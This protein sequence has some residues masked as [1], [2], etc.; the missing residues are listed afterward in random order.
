M[1]K[2]YSFGSNIQEVSN[3]KSFKFD[4]EETN[5]SSALSYFPFLNNVLVSKVGTF[6]FNKL[7]GISLGFLSITRR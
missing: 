2:Y 6:L 1:E 7:E 5:L 4:Q 3:F